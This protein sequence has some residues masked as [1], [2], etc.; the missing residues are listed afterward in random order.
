MIGLDSSRNLMTDMD[1]IENDL[2]EKEF[3]VITNWDDDLE[4]HFESYD[5]DNLIYLQEVDI[6]YSI[7][8]L[9]KGLLLKAPIR[10]TGDVIRNVGPVCWELYIPQLKKLL[11]N[12]F[13]TKSNAGK[14]IKERDCFTCQLCGEQDKRVLNTHHIVPRS[15]PFTSKSFIDSPVNQITLCANCH[16]IEH[17]ILEHG[18]RA[19]IRSHVKRMFEV[20]GYD[21]DTND[22]FDIPMNEIRKWN[23]IEIL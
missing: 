5:S 10:L 14:Q 22:G 7:Y 1:H 3:L 9:E 12:R 19:E 4:Y 18:S 20:N 23:K 13:I 17:Y 2:K 11:K 16:T 8:D 21:W 6:V 15:S